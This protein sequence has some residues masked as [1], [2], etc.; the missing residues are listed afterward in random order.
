MTNEEFLKTI[1]KSFKAYIDAGTSRSTAK[2][3]N[4]HGNIAQDA[5]NI[6][7]VNLLLN[8]KVSMMA[9]RPVYKEDIMPKMLI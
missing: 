7:A 1:K 5:Q 9:K 6:L 4:L 3:K 2:L 8:R